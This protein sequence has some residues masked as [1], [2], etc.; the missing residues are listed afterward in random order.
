MVPLSGVSRRTMQAP[1]RR[2]FLSQ[3]RQQCRLVFACQ[4]KRHVVRG[5]ALHGRLEQAADWSGRLCLRPFDNPA[6]ACRFLPSGFRHESL[7]IAS[8][9][10]GCI[11]VRV[12][13]YLLASP[14]SNNL[15]M[16]HTQTQWQIS[17]THPEV[18]GDEHHRHSVAFFAQINNQVQ[19]LA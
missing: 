3:I 14:S 1:Q 16:A 9:Q 13:Q 19:N 10:G 15:A 8:N 17:A 18:M 7:G 12:G 4:R 2:F 11:H 5:L 6:T